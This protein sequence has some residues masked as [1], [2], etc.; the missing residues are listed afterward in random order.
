MIILLFIYRMTQLEAAFFLIVKSCE[1]PSRCPN[2]KPSHELTILTMTRGHVN[3]HPIDR[4][5]VK[6]GDA[7]VDVT[8]VGPE[9]PGAQKQALEE[10]PQLE[11]AEM[12]G[13]SWRTGSCARKS[14]FLLGT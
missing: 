6:E 1:I 2:S 8:L 12:D 13:S 3:H 4:V 14:T 10:G 5:K 9:T 11:M 7:V